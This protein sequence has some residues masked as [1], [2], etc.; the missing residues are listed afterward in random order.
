MHISEETNCLPKPKLT[1]MTEVEFAAMRKEEGARVV[2]CDG[3]YWENTFPGFFQ[4]IHLLARFNAGAL[5]RPSLFCW[6]YRAALAE[7][8]AHVANG[9]IPVHLTDVH[10]FSEQSLPD[11]RKEDLRRCR[12]QVQFRQEQDPAIFLDQ[13][14]EV[15]RSAQSRVPHGKPMTREQYLIDIKKRVSDPRWIFIIGVVQG[16]LAGY[17]ENYAVDDTIYGHEMYVATDQ[18]RTGIGTGLDIELIKLAAEFQSIQQICWGYHCPERQ[19]ITKYKSTISNVVQVASHVSIPS[20]A[21]SLIKTRR[22][23]TYYHL[24]G[25]KPELA[26]KS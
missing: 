19:G 12:R 2:E 9:S 14:W 22:P 18:M 11:S 4:P 8:D 6:G 3:R 10:G 16:K 26:L 13:G 1:V 7:E 25:L 23:R 5:R 21:E 24:T 17:V 15:F 20:M